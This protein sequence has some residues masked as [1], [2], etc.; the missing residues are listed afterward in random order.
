MKFF[1]RNLYFCH[2]GENKMVQQ[3]GGIWIFFLR[4]NFSLYFEP[5]GL[6]FELYSFNFEFSSSNFDFQS[7]TYCVMVLT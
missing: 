2:F 6:Q 7:R 1:L 4:W 3:S 5:S